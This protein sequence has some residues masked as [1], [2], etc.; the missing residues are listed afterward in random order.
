V[1][2]L[3]RVV[4]INELIALFTSVRATTR[5]SA[6]T[7]ATGLRTIFT[8]IQR[9][10]TI[11][12]LRNLNI[13]LRD[14]QGNFVGAF[15]AVKRLSA[16]LA[17]IDP[18][19]GT[20]SNIV[21]ELG[22]FR[23]IG[24]V[25]PL[26]QQ[27]G[28]A[29]DA[30]RVAQAASGSTAKD[31]ATAQQGLGVQIQKVREEFTALIRKFTDSGPFNTIATGALKIASA[32]IKVAEAVEP[33]LPLLTTMFGLK[34]GRALAPG[35]ANL[36]GIARGGGGGGGRGFS[37]FARGGI[38]PGSGNRDTVP[39][40]LTPGE[41]VIKKSSV[42]NLGAGTLAAMNE[43]RL[44]HGGKPQRI[45]APA[46]GPT[47]FTH[48]DKIRSVP[49]KFKS[50]MAKFGVTNIDRLYSNLG[51]DLPAVWN[52]DWSRG[53]DNHGVFGTQVIDYV[54]KNKAD[55]IDRDKFLKV[56][57]IFNTITGNTRTRTSSTKYAAS[58]P[59]IANLLNDSKVTGN[60][61]R[62]FTS[63]LG[64]VRG[65][66]L[67]T[68]PDVIRAGIGDILLQSLKMEDA[69]L[70]AAFKE[71][72]TYKTK[73]GGRTGIRD[74][75][76]SVAQTATR[77]RTQGKGFAKG[78]SVSDTIPA[79]LTP[80]EFVFNKSSA[81]SIGYSNLNRMNKQGVQGF[82]AGGVVGF[83]NGGQAFG[84]GVF[85]PGQDAASYKAFDTK[86]DDINQQVEKAAKVTA[87][88]TKAKE[89]NTKTT[90]KNNTIRAKASKQ[91]EN[92]SKRLA[93]AR[94]GVREFGGSLARGLGR[95]DGIAQ[96]AQS[97]VF[98]AI[99]IGTVTSQLSGLSDTTKTAINRT[100]TF[101][102]TLI[103]IGAT[104]VSTLAGVTT[105]LVANRLAT[106]A[107]TISKTKNAGSSTLASLF[108]GG[109]SPTGGGAG[110]GVGGIGALL[111]GLA[112]P[113]TVVIGLF[114]AAAV[115][116][117]FYNNKLKAETE[118]LAQAA[119]ALVAK[120]KETGEGAGESLAAIIA[121]AKAA[122]RPTAL[123]GEQA[124]ALTRDQIVGATITGAGAARGAE[125]DAAIKELAAAATRS[126]SEG[127]SRAIAEQRSALIIEKRT[128][129]ENQLNAV[130][131][132][133]ISTLSGL[134]K[135]S[136]DLS[137]AY[138]DL[139]SR[140]ENISPEQRRTELTDL[141][142]Q[143]SDLITRTTAQA[144]SQIQ[145]LIA[146]RSL[147]GI[148]GQ[149]S[150]TA[151]IE[152]QR[153]LASGEVQGTQGDIRS[154]NALIL[155]FEALSQA[156]K[157]AQ[158][159]LIQN[160]SNLNEFAKTID[161]SKTEAEIM[162]GSFGDAA[163]ASAKGIVDQTNARIAEIRERKRIA[164]GLGDTDTA[165]ALDEEAERIE[166]DGNERLKAEAKYHKTIITS[167]Q[168]RH[169]A[170][171]RAIAATEAV[172]KEQKR[173]LGL[174]SALDKEIG[175][176]ERD[177]KAIE[178]LTNLRGGGNISLEARRLTNTDL[179]SIVTQGQR[180]TLRGE[181]NSII[182]SAPA[183]QQADL[184]RSRDEINRAVANVST[185][186]QRAGA[187]SL[188]LIGARSLVAGGDP[189]GV[190]K[191]IDQV[192]K[193]TPQEIRTQIIEALGVEK[194]GDE[195]SPEELA[196]ALRQYTD[197]SQQQIDAITKVSDVTQSEI[198]L[199]VARLNELDR[200]YNAELS[201]RQALL[202]TQEQIAGIGLRSAKL[203]AQS[204]GREIQIRKD[205]AGA[206]QRRQRKAQADLDAAG[207]G[208]DVGDIAGL[209]KRGEELRREQR[210]IAA[211]AA[212]PADRRDIDLLEKQRKNTN[213]LNA[214][215]KELERLAT[216]T[217]AVDDLFS[218]MQ[219]NLELIEKERRKREQVLGVVEEFVVGGQDTRKA[220]VDSANGIR[221]AFATGTLQN[222]T[223][224]QRAATVGLLDKLS[225]VPL[226]NGFTGG[227]IKQE[228]I[229][230]DAIKL[231]LDPK[232]AQALATA[233]TKEQ[234]LI[235]SNERL[236]FQ[237]FLLTQE[238]T[239]ARVAQGAL[240]LGGF[241]NG[242]MVQYRAGGGSIFKPRGTDTVRLC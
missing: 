15:E 196:N 105:A 93:S 194:I 20:F 1:Y 90:S 147:R 117:S 12:Q 116:I 19:S 201:S 183:A 23:Q 107:E 149:G 108:P 138:Q 100:A 154:A 62:N 24:K 68:D 206:E 199:R 163:R 115:A 165:K 130:L 5:E 39:A 44:N 187:G 29:Q 155:S 54:R 95:L 146:S 156:T 207:V 220:L 35:V 195:I 159:A 38:V 222:Q 69:K 232:I 135:E 142:Q 60:I 65:K 49:T 172:I 224:Q 178:N 89:T 80:G 64:S 33:L 204:N 74:E 223:E 175:R 122:D 210:R 176:N 113:L 96:S 152:N 229:F 46:G 126:T 6:E 28:T 151:F 26:I 114:T 127:Q 233:T 99:T 192:L 129:L 66:F 238:M 214:V 88:N 9:T 145:D 216:R 123:G 3:V 167:A 52:L 63:R 182:A 27:F 34:L 208:K 213:Q 188:G 45:V 76:R 161:G 128:L 121:A 141:S 242:G 75:A 57:G 143:R 190:K 87:T 193:D 17:T 32:M 104:V 13:E 174:V 11:D 198:D 170:E 67:D 217:G 132:D 240:G 120:L 140:S 185:L 2:F 79:L 43:N 109:R 55:T 219:A 186:N 103:G 197:L 101:F 73:E 118:K 212:L 86:W 119:G 166:K 136:K 98:L 16:G 226:L 236:A 239:Q 82:A 83:A 133:S 97:F 25:I 215:N 30:L 58:N 171:M 51:L 237:L 70:A 36:A 160:R 72:S 7:I 137:A 211:Q 235:D 158:Q 234:Q 200:M 37:R 124:G 231:G 50:K 205:F 202:E 77:R 225:D 92:F 110:K 221:L 164:I 4:K 157:Q 41:F 125:I 112:G 18:R 106:E 84:Q 8:R 180:D 10:E 228:L 184:Q 22:G 48:L 139:Q 102:G 189:Q 218:E 91:M 181:I 144:S 169:Q 230:R 47:H 131:S 14:S 42:K 150:T 53:K 31:A 81:Q 94:A 241:A 78:G 191:V 148:G 153:K 61:V 227:Q 173:I 21:E 111:S 85:P 59:K 162:S 71:I 134:V 168:E 177:T 40:M 56:K 203:I 209:R 179:A